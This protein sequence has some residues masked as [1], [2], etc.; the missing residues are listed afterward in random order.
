MEIAAERVAEMRTNYIRGT[1]NTLG[2]VAII[3]FFRATAPRTVWPAKPCAI[4]QIRGRA[5]GSGIEYRPAPDGTPGPYVAV[6]DYHL[7][8]AAYAAN[9]FRVAA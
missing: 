8:S 2:N 7:M 5:S 1:G 9:V 3:R 6:C 4:C